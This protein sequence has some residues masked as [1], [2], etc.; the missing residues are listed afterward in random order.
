MGFRDRDYYHEGS[1]DDGGYTY[2]R[3]GSPWMITT[4]L[5]VINIALYLIDGLFF[6]G[7]D[8][9]FWMGTHGFTL[10]HPLYY[11]EFLTAGFAHSPAG[12]NHIL[13][14]M[15]ALFFFGYLIEER[16][17]RYEYLRFY[18]F[19]VVFG[20][21]AHSLVSIGGSDFWSLGASG[22]ITALVVMFALWYPHQQ[23]MLFF[24][25]PMPAWVAGALLVGMDMYG[26]INGRGL[27][28]TE[29]LAGSEKIGYVTHLGGA[30]FACCYHF[31]RWNIGTM[32]APLS[33]PFRRMLRPGK[34]KF[35]V[36]DPENESDSR[37]SEEDAK[38][39]EQ[40][41]AILEKIAKSG[42]ASLTRSERET[43]KKA[44][45]KYR[46]KYR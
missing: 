16:M 13:F 15:L 25:I 5:L 31:L 7:H 4:W 23:I 46:K 2:R 20:N 27:G 6:P 19:A 45:R 41:D 21:L 44:S 38:L 28:L 3:S 14:N 12:I 32:F 24:V 22:A 36:Y 29:S 34:P 8:L 40:V 10:F 26:A 35:R 37:N 43:L 17:G 33:A 1:Y 11:W 39:T 42:E 30:A 9:M 18:L